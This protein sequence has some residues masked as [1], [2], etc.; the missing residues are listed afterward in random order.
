MR[1]EERYIARPVLSLNT[2]LHEIA[3]VTPQVRTVLPGGR[4]TADTAAAVRSFQKYAGL[5]VTGKADLA[6]WNAV[7]AAYRR[8]ALALTPPV[9]A[10]IWEISQQVN[11]GEEN[12]HVYLAQAMLL[13]LSRKLGGF[14]PPQVTGRLD[15]AT[16]AALGWLQGRCSLKPTGMLDGATW[17]A[18]SALYRITWGDGSTGRG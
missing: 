17:R 8:A 5:P 4:F 14:T 10:P 18:L 7:V 13:A 12:S 11:A 6:T 1:R 2:M 16:A 15:T 3:A 9:I